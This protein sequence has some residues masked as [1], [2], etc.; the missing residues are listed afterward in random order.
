MVRVVTQRAAKTF[1]RRR[2]ITLLVEGEPRVQRILNL[3]SGLALTPP[4]LPVHGV[5]RLRLAA[6]VLRSG[7]ATPRRPIFQ[8]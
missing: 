5:P 2:K 4:L 3:T 8:G 1:F 7:V 6:Y